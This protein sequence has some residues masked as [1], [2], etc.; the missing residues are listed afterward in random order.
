MPRQMRRTR[1]SAEERQ[2]RKP[3]P[4]NDEMRHDRLHVGTGPTPSGT[5][6]RPSFQL[7]AY[8][9]PRTSHVQPSDE[10]IPPPM[11]EKERGR[12]ER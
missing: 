8:S 3:S 9:P 6:P 10:E 1:H 11:V 4:K 12:Q 2:D 5:R 7:P